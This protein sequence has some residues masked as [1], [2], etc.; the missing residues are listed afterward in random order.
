MCQ[1]YTTEAVKLVKI[2]ISL[3]SCWYID[4]VILGADANSTYHALL[5]DIVYAIRGSCA[6]I[7]CTFNISDFE[8][9][10]NNSSSIHAVWIKGKSQFSDNPVVFNGTDNTTKL[11]ERIEILGNLRQ[12]DCTTVFYNVNQSHTDKY[13]FRTEMT[14]FRATF[15]EKPFNLTVN[16]RR[17]LNLSWYFNITLFYSILC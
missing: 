5:P 16:G 13:F 10:L 17:P 14:H 2:D 6:L 1:Y 11:L 7:P 12:R 8:A 9:K 3:E 4:F 15:L